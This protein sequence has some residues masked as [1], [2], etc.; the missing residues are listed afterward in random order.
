MTATIAAP[1][2]VIELLDG[3]R[4]HVMAADD[5]HLVIEFVVPPMDAPNAPHVHASADEVFEVLA[6]H[7][8]LTLD[9]VAH[10]LAAGDSIVIPHGAVH[11]W[12]VV[13]GRDLDARVTFT[14]GC[15]FDAFL[16]DL[17]ALQ[18]AGR[19]GAD[20]RPG[21]RDFALMQRRH[22]RDLRLTFAP[23]PVLRVMVA[24]GVALAVLTGRELPEEAPEELG[25][26]VRLSGA[27]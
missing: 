18:R 20:G 25:A 27:S 1:L 4:H 9:G 22:W 17:A 14:P 13:G 6:G 8:L 11:R 26:A 23:K 12:Q 3:Q 16:R 10:H 15:A 5:E 2:D 21:F 7:V 19:T 24:A